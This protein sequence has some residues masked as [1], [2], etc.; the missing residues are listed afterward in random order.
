MK[1]DFEAY[2]EERPFF[3]FKFTY[4]PIF[5]NAAANARGRYLDLGAGD[6]GQLH[7]LISSAIA[8][9]FSEYY[10]ADISAI[11][12]RRLA[13][14]LPGVTVVVADAQELPFPDNYF[15]FIFS[16]QVIEHVPDD[17]AMARELRRVLK[18]GGLAVVGSILRLRGG[19]Y[20]RRNNGN[21]RLDATHIREYESHG[22][23]ASVFESAGLS[24]DEIATE[25]L[26]YPFLDG[27]FRLALWAR[28]IN[29]ERLLQFYAKSTVVQ[30]LRRFALR[31]P[32]YYFIF[33][34]VSK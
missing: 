25:P 18:P 7:S 16:N 14:T 23:Y 20:F 8:D 1:A 34:R 31:I 33:A 13:E 24:V 21:W 12:C 3:W 11:R 22:E 2:A 17:L 29:T 19:W 30:S 6:G 15:D 10:A 32:R 26:R 4:P 27:M 5:L 9:R 28:L